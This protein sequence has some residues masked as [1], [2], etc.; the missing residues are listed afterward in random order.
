LPQEDA[1]GAT[2]VGLAACCLGGDCIFRAFMQ[3]QFFGFARANRMNISLGEMNF[4]EPIGRLSNRVAS[5][6]F[7]IVMGLGISL[8]LVSV[9]N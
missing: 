3:I 9:L 8:Y 5:T 6:M 7:F 2:V 1:R 4:P